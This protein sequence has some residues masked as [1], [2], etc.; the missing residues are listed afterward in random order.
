MGHDDPGDDVRWAADRAHWFQVD[1]SYELMTRSGFWLRAGYGAAWMLNPGDAHCEL[2]LS[3]TRVSCESGRVEGSAPD[4]VL[5]T[6]TI[7]L[8][9][10]IR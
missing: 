1:V 10:A 5:P 6:V 7:V 9:Y 4:E 8:G 3:G 2:E